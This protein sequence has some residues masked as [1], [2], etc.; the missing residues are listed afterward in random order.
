[1]LDIWQ[2]NGVRDSPFIVL[3]L[4][5]MWP[6]FTVFMKWDESLGMQVLCFITE[7]EGCLSSLLLPPDVSLKDLPDCR[8]FPSWTHTSP[9]RAPWQVL[10]IPGPASPISTR[11][12]LKMTWHQIFFLM[13]E[14][15]RLECEI[16]LPLRLSCESECWF[17][18]PSMKR[19]YEQTV[20]MLRLA[21]LCQRNWGYF[22][23]QVFYFKTAYIFLLV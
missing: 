5:T 2:H 7:P 13:L 19:V 12:V 15:W 23:H 14:L 20:Q 4:K 17:H 18:K 9:G 21:S 8:H 1:M 10:D 6:P 22:W 3:F 16:W 11:S